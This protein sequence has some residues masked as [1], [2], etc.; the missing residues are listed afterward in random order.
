MKRQLNVLDFAAIKDGDRRI[1]MVTC[2]DYWSA[3]VLGRTDIDCLLVGDSLAM[4]M[5]GYDS[6]VYADVHLMALHTRAVA[7]G[8][9]EKFIIADMPFLSVRKG[10]GPAMDAVQALMQ[11]GA[12]AVKIEGEA[13]HLDIIGHIVESGV[14]VM[15]HLGLTP[16]AVHGLGGHRVQARGESA[17][18]TLVSAASRLADAGCFALVLECVPAAVGRCVSAAVPIPTIGIGAGPHTDGQVLVLQDM[19]GTNPDFKPRFLRHYA[20]G[21]ATIWEAVNRF[22][23]DVQEGVY[24]SPEESYA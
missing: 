22:H 13:G 5:H 6:T 3:Q 24:P 20:D 11:S 12:S 14:P 15:G 10:V 23:T 18:Q 16:Q 17:G 21:F 9:P 7:L 19:L 4:V 8:A 1:S 2:Y